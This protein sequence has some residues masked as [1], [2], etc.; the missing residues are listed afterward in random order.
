[1]KRNEP[2]LGAYVSY[3]HVAC[4]GCGQ[5]TRIEVCYPVVQASTLNKAKYCPLCGVE[6]KRENRVSEANGTNFQ[7][8]A[9]SLMSRTPT[10]EDVAMIQSIYPLWDAYKHPTFKEFLQ[11]LVRGS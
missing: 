11:S 7:L 10:K 9:A 4:H 1:L 3:T 8:V 6:F 2:Q 5:L